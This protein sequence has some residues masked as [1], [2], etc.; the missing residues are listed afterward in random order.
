[1]H[2]G[3]ELV[4]GDTVYSCCLTRQN[5][6]FSVALDTLILGRTEDVDSLSMAVDT[7]GHNPLLKDMG[8]VTSR[9][10]DL[11]PHGIVNCIA[12]LTDHAL[13]IRR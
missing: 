10:G 1:M 2:G 8:L 6:F 3:Q 5:Q 13:N 7:I 12:V 9:L 4:A 11:G